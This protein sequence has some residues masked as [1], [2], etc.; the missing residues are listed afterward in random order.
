MSDP[1]VSV[2]PAPEGPVA[3]GPVADGPVAGGRVPDGV[4]AGEGG[5]PEP[6]GMSAGRIAGAASLLSVGNIL[7]RLLGLVRTQT[8][9]HFFGTSLQADAFNFASKAPQTIYDLLVG[10][11]LHGAVVPVLSDYHSRRREEFW[12]AASVLFT[13]AAVVS[14]AASV[15][16]YL[17]AD[18]LAP[19]LIDG[20]SLGAEA[21]RLTAGN[22]RWMALSILLFGMAGISTGI[23]YVVG[24]YHVAA[25]AMPI[26]NL[27][28]IGG[29]FLLRPVLGYW[30]LAFSVTLGGLAQVLTLAWGLRDSRLRPAW[31]LRHPALRRSMVLYGPVAAGLL[32]TQVQIL[33]SVRLAS[34]AGPG[35]GSM[36]NYADRLIQFPQGIIASS[37]AVAILP[38]LAAAH[39]EGRRGSYQRSLARGL[40]LVLCLVLPAAVGMA[41]LAGPIIGLAF[42][43]GEFGDAS[44]LG[45]TLALWAYLIG[46]PLAAI[47]LSLIN[48]FYA[49]Q[50]TRA[51]ALVGALSVGVYLAA[52]YVLG[53][54][55]HVLGATP[56][57]LIVGLALADTIKHASHVLMML[58]LLHRIDEAESLTGVGGGAW[59][60]GLAAL[61]MGLA[62]AGL[63]RLLAGPAGLNAG[64][65]AW[66]LRAL[67]GS[68][69]GAAVYL[70]LAAFLGV[71]EIRWAGD[72]L[73]QRLRRG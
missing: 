15:A 69:L 56:Q 11:Q 6:G 51:P 47:D 50:N 72:L 44:R 49:R 67:A 57:L 5:H 8:I 33:A 35:V 32:L 9:A 34:M 13:V 23:L 61:L 54:G 73:R 18:L 70:P 20:T 66:G 46:L 40:R 52:A 42:Q 55:R 31:D 1:P 12:R 19:A 63:D 38:A 7:S 65:L 25:V 60:S 21:L 27:A 39:A 2:P 4:T 28:M 22:L 58:W 62:V 10:G 48:A 24:R 43:S 64:K 17:S 68:A 45:V 26:Y 71:E 53:P 29:F 36:L 14:A 41:V 37:V 16:V 3:D 30:A 59:R